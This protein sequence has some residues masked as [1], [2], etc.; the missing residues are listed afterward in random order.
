MKT[1]ILTGVIAVCLFVPFLIFANSIAFA[2]VF[3]AVSLIGVWEMLGC[4]GLRREWWISIP[5]FLFGAGVP[6]LTL[7]CETQNAFFVVFVT[8][9]LVLLLYL[10]CVTVLA[11][12]RLPI[13]D[14]SVATLFCLYIVAG[15]C[16]MIWLHR[17][18]LESNSYIYFLPFVAAWITDTFAY[19][20]GRFFGRHKLAPTISPKKTIEGSIGGIVFCVIFVLLYA[21]IIQRVTDLTPRLW[22]F[23]VA[24]VFL[25]VVSQIGDLI[26][27]V[28]KRHYGVKD[29]GKLLPGHG[30][31]LDRFDST[32]AVSVLLTLIM[33]YVD[34]F[35]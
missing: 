21:L 34:L 24:G 14:L 33:Q 3:A 20:A 8:I 16:G 6:V 15:F 10:F 22:L 11:G 29:Y 30:G 26:L 32:L 25:S 13:T 18:H 23:A 1:R 2:A 31:I 12:G 7:F 5:L 17:A 4:T 35:V 28:V 19:F 9:M 27:S